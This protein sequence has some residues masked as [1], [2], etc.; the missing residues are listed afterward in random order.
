MVVTDRRTT[1]ATVVSPFEK[2]KFA[3]IFIAAEV[4]VGRVLP[5]GLGP[6]LPVRHANSLLSPQQAALCC[7]LSALSFILSA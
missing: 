6:V 1:L 5:H 4:A 3:R 7:L 2:R